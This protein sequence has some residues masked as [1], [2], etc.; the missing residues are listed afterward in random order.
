MDGEKLT[1]AVREN[2]SKQNIQY[3]PF[4]SIYP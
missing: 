3:G 4:F 1:W 2:L